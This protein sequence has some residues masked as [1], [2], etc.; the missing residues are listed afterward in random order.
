MTATSA[1]NTFGIFKNSKAKKLALL[2]NLSTTDKNHY[3]HSGK[4]IT[5][6]DVQFIV[7]NLWLDYFIYNTNKPLNISFV[8]EYY[9]FENLKIKFPELINFSI[10]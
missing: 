1:K 10:A 5:F 6:H 8:V 9:L 4:F 3:I 2:Y 7:D